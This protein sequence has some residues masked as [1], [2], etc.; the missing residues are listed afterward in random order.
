MATS[1]DAETA[2]AALLWA[3][4][5]P[6]ASKTKV[7]RGWPSPSA[8][9]NEIKAGNVIVSVYRLDVSR[10]TT[11]YLGTPTSATVPP[12]TLGA[13]TAGSSA[14]FTGTADPG[15]IAGV[16]AAGIA[17][18]VRTVVGD[19]PS[20]IAAKVAQQMPGPVIVSGP[21][22]TAAG[23]SDARTAADATAYREVG[24]QE[25]TLQADA[26]C[27]TPDLRDQVEVLVLPA[28]AAATFLAMPDGSRARARLGAVM[29]SDQAS[30][31][32]IYRLMLRVTAEVT[33]NTSEQAAIML[34]PDPI[35]SGGV[36]V[37]P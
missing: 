14:T 27:P 26:W 28:V 7:I 19:T 12:P 31:L 10:N 16:I 25:N 3:A 36:A 32:T 8:L 24:R 23:L 21:T 6:I 29:A 9:D 30:P 1:A 34:W 37:S 17:Y 11:R 13:T 5:S 15:Q 18:P 33:L 2:L 35:L 20:T 22:I 4:L